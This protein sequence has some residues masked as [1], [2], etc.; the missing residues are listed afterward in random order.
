MAENTEEISTTRAIISL[1]NAQDNAA[2]EMGRL[3]TALESVSDEVKA[4]NGGLR[5]HS[6]RLALSEQWVTHHTGENGVHDVG[7]KRVDALE[8]LT[9]VAIAIPTIIVVGGALAGIVSVLF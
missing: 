8:K 4:I 2:R 1:A 6:I 5:E 9:K 3:A 7:E